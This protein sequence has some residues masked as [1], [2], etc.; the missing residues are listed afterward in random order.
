MSVSSFAVSASDL[1]ISSRAGSSLAGLS[2]E[3]APFSRRSYDTERIVTP[4]AFRRSEWRHR[5][6]PSQSPA[7]RRS[8]GDTHGIT[9]RHGARLGQGALGRVLGDGARNPV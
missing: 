2:S 1:P 5:L 4:A 8:A 3:S 6:Y 7:C 9:G